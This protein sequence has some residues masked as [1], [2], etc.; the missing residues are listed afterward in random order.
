MSESNLSSFISTNYFNLRSAANSS[1]SISKP[2]T[3]K[4]IRNQKSPTNISGW[5]LKKKTLQIAETTWENNEKDSTHSHYLMTGSMAS[6]TATSL[7][8]YSTN[9]S[10]LGPSI[11]C[12]LCCIYEV[13]RDISTR[14]G[15]CIINCNTGQ[16]YLSDFMD[17][18]IYIRV[19]H[20][21]Q[22]YQPTEIL[23]PSSSL[24][25]TVSKLATMI[26]FNVAETVKIEEG[27]RKCFN[28]Q[29]GLAAITKYL[30]DDT[31]KD[32][33]IEEIIDKTFALCAASAAIS[34]ME[35]IISKSSRNLNAFRKLRIQFEGTENTMLIDSK[36]VRGLEL[37]ENKLDKNGI[38]LWKFL[39]TTS[40]KMGQRSLRNSILQP[41]TDRGSIEMRLEAL[42][43]LKANDDLLQ[44]LRLE[45]KSLPDLDKLFSR[46]LCINHSAIKPD[47]R[48]NYVLLLKETLQSVK[49]LKDAL[50]DQLIQS[51]LISETKKI[52]N[53]DAIMEIEK[54]INSCINEDCVWASSAIQLL[55]QRSYAVKSDSNGLLDVSRQ[56]YKEV[57]EEFFRE[58]EDLT[59]NNKINLDHNY[60][61]A[62]GF[63]LRIKRQEFTDDV[64]TLPDVFISRTIKKNYIECTTLN[65]IK[66]NARLKEVM[67]E[68]LLLSEETV[69]ELLD[70]IATHISELFMIA[71]AVAILD[72]VCSFT[73]NLK[74]NN[75]T[76]PIFTNNL[77]IR[78]S[79]HPLLEKVLK[80]FV[81]NTISSTKHSSSLQIITGCNMSGKSVYLKQVALICIMAQMGSGIPALYGS[82]PVFKRLHARVC[83]DSMELTSS[84]FGFEMKEMAY[85]LDD[86]NTETLLILDELGRG[87]SIADGF[88]V[89]LAVTEHLLRTEATVFLSTHFQDIPKIM[90]K[91][92]A[93][94]HLH[95]DAVLLNDN[96]VKMNYQLTQKS[97]AIENSGIRVVKK[98]FNPDIIAEA[99]NIHSLLKIAKARTENEDSNG[100]VDQKTINQM[101]RIHNL[102]AILKECAG[103]E[104][105]PLTLGK[106]KEINS[107]FIE[108]FEE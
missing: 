52:F 64:A 106:L 73:Y 66:K 9:A 46:L 25:P 33:K 77:L 34:Y 3:K 22:I 17:S 32:L 90:S 42:E 83:N 49:S 26:K 27:S 47:Q 24:A 101:K 68:I 36:T 35:E 10:L 72:L 45:M 86:I 93:V 53:N 59:A 5:A 60:D 95:M 94:S 41:L 105:E 15:L 12:V 99:Y 16:M 21:L 89:S 70:K 74:E 58:V 108:N 4:S 31:K 100:I 97:V 79:R 87:S 61:S 37:V 1:N 8:R 98:I 30:M 54:L 76:I 69:D 84:N 85:F 48:I 88:C 82:F 11:D 104:K 20:K 78:D 96:S 81:P 56:I 28:S 102:V 23:I 80:N 71:E 103:N 44:K 62:R 7:S 91:K 18:Q 57:K 14:I 38:S 55:N 6:R 67:E 75:Y 92:P 50:N 107:D 39:D 2:S 13:P 51:R 43:E 19:V 40:T 65:I 29:D 63:Y